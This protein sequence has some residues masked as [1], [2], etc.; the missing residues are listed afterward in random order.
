MAGLENR[1]ILPEATENSD[2]S[3]FGVYPGMTEQMMGY[4]LETIGEYCTS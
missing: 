1:F 4:M 3:W 2:P